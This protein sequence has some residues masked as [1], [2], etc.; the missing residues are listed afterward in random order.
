VAGV[1][2]SVY[3][4]KAKGSTTQVSRFNFSSGLEI[5]LRTQTGCVAHPV[6]YSIGSERFT[7]GVKL[8][9]YEANH[10]SPYSHK[11]KIKSNY[12]FTAYTGPAFSF[13]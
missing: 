6:S 8:P 12:T 11:V 1:A 5:F 7:P 2:L 13:I 10:C 4:E 3:T 9:M